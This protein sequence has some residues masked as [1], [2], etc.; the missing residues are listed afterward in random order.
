MTKIKEDI[1]NKV[2]P[3]NMRVGI[4]MGKT[5]KNG[6]I[7]IQCS[8]DKDINTVKGKIGN[9]LGCNYTVNK[10]QLHRNRF[11][12][13]DINEYEYVKTDNKMALNEIINQNYLNLLNYCC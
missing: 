10:K 6:G 2:N 11:K 13:L 3:A 7:F 12:I 8:D 9:Y 5:T 1:R 4:T